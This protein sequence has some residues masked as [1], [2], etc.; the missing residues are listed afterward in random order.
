MADPE[1]E[2]KR[3]KKLSSPDARTQK[4]QR[5]QQK[6]RRSSTLI[7]KAYDL[8]ELAD[9]D[10][11]LGIRDRTTGRIKTF[12]SDDDTGFW[13]SKMSHLDTYYPVPE[14]KTPKDFSPRKKTKTA[15]SKKHA[16]QSSSPELG[17]VSP[18]TSSD[19]A[20]QVNKLD[21]IKQVNESASYRKR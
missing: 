2:V 6:S 3:Q 10:V 7:R 12:C 17:S 20:S 4:K 13:S 1:H 14:Q 18:A 21:S 8:S 9:V 19:I 5:R 16:R 15:T 11:F